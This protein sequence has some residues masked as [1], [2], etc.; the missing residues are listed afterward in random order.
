VPSGTRTKVLPGFG[1]VSHLTGRSCKNVPRPTRNTHAAAIVAGKCRPRQLQTNAEVAVVAK[2]PPEVQ[3][4][5]VL[6]TPYP[7]S[8]SSSAKIALR[9]CAGGW[10]SPRFDLRSGLG[11]GGCLPKGS[12]RLSPFHAQPVRIGSVP[13]PSRSRGV[14]LASPQLRG[15]VRARLS[16]LL[17]RAPQQ[18]A[19]FVGPKTA[20]LT[21]CGGWSRRGRGTHRSAELV[22]ILALIRGERVETSARRFVRLGVRF[23]PRRSFA[24]SRQALAMVRG[25]D[26]VAPR[27]LRLRADTTISPASTPHKSTRCRIRSQVESRARCGGQLGT[28]ARCAFVKTHEAVHVRRPLH[29][30]HPFLHSEVV[31]ASAGVSGTPPVSDFAHS[32][33]L[34]GSRAQLPASTTQN[35]IWS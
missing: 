22:E 34:L 25:S 4:D 26:T 14:G 19:D 31:L 3:A 29:V 1:A 11:Q 7:V 6:S 5:H 27:G 8:R 28:L 21:H 13:P 23:Q 32:V 35:E 33:S 15:D 30:L 18:S 20:N 16:R 9:Q 2:L 12:L 24:E 10:A 17:A